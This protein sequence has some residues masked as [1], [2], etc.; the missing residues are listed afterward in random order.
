MPGTNPTAVDHRAFITTLLEEAA[1]ALKGPS[2]DDWYDRLEREHVQLEEV[3]K[4]CLEHDPELGRK[5]GGA[6]WRFWMSQ[7][8]IP[9]GRE[10]LRRLLAAPAAEARTLGRAHALYGAGTLAFMQGDG[11]AALPLHKESLAIAEELG[12][13]GAV[14]DAL[15]GLARVGLL[16]GDIPEM[17]RRSEQSLA[18]ARES[19]D[20]P[21]E[22]L[23]LHHVVEA[24]RRQGE[25]EAVIPLYHE[26]IRLQRQLGSERGV[27]LEL[28][29]LGNVERKRGNLAA[30][31]E[32][33]TQSLAVYGRLKAKRN[34][35]YCF[36]G[37]GNVAAAEGNVERS[38]RLIA[39][40]EKLFNETGV[41]LDP[42]YLA[43]CEQSKSL[44][45]NSLGDD[46]A[47]ITDEARGML[48]EDA[49]RYAARSS[50]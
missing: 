9:E 10:W 3:L 21:A 37:L 7:G 28:H 23:A 4:W 1:P 13:K 24:R 32:L 45:K 36:L 17:L 50:T 19:G 2:P 5:L 38:A 11:D 14:A 46:F 44:T 6:V 31:A 42:D 30:A 33:L 49:I 26:S 15:I 39:V 16:A 40:A 43:D 29:N 22:A 8:H 35:G 18:V 41:A 27:A 48:L 47:R 12:D 25:L 34:L 20:V